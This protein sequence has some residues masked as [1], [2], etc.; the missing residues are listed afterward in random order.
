MNLRGQEASQEAS[1]DARQDA[2]SEQGYAMAALLVALAVMTILLT[3]AM[4]VWKTAAKREKEAELVWRASQYVRA[5][6]LFRRKYANASPPNLDILVNERFLRKKY[7]DPMTK[8]GEFQLVYA[9]EQQQR[10]GLNPPN[11]ANPA[12][13]APAPLDP[14]NR[15]SAGVGG[16]VGVSSKS[17]EASLRMFNGRSKYNEWVFTPET[18]GIR[19]QGAGNAPGSPVPGGAAGAVG[20]GGRPVGPGGGFSIDRSGRR[21]P[22]QPGQPG[23]PQPQRP[24]GLPPQRPPQ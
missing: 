12:N 14:R 9:S 21:T 13:P 19:M 11:P 8:D 6:M 4:P 16:I 7:K 22:L 3:V 10:P 5:I 24:F 15:G 2:R 1:R 18:L 17:K 23:Q 20:P